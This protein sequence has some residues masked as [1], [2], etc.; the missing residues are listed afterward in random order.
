MAG[1]DVRILI[2]AVD[3]ASRVLDS[4]AG[5]SAMLGLGMERTGQSL[6]SVGRG[7]Q[8]VADPIKGAIQS[9]MSLE[10]V[11]ADVNKVLGAEEVA[12]AGV[13]KGLMEMSRRIPMTVQGLAAISAAGGSLGLPAKEVLGFTEVAAKMGIA[14]DM[15][16]DR[17]GV[18]IAKLRNV[19]SLD[20]KGGVKEV[21]ALGDT[22]NALENDMSLNAADAVEAMTRIGGTT[23][24]FGLSADQAAA[25]ASSIIALGNA[26]DVAATA[27]NSILPSLQTATGGTKAFKDGLLMT[28]ISAEQMSEMVKKDGMGAINS[29]LQSLQRLDPEGRALAIKKMF[30]AGA[31]ARALNTLANDAGQL[32][33]ALG[34]INDKTKKQGSMEREF[35][36]RSAT[37][38]NS[39]QL[40]QN[41]LAE[42]AITVGSVLLPA[43]ESVTRAIMPVVQGFASFAQTYPNV[44]KLAAAALIV[45]AG[46]GAIIVALG[47]VISFVGAAI[48]G[49]GTLA[50]A[51][52]AASGAIVAAT[53]WIA[54]VG[55]IGAIV[56]S[57]GTIITTALGGAAAAV[58]AL[59]LPFIAVA[60]LVAGAAFL[61]V[62]N[63]KPISAFFVGLFTNPIATLK[64]AAATIGALFSGLPGRVLPSL[65]GLASSAGATFQG[66]GQ[67]IA[68][69]FNW[70]GEQIAGFWRRIGTALT[71]VGAVIK[72][73]FEGWLTIALAPYRF[74]FG[75]L[76][77][78]FQQ[79]GQ[80]IAPS[81]SG[82]GGM[83]AGA[84][85]LVRSAVSGIVATFTA[86][87][88]GVRQ[89]IGGTAS[90]VSATFLG[91][92][93]VIRS[94]LDQTGAIFLRFVATIRGVLQTTQALVSGFVGGVMTTVGGIATRVSAVMNSIASAVVGF[95]AQIVGQ[96]QSVVTAFSTAQ[97]SGQSM[98]AAVGA[99]LGQVI[100]IIGSIIARVEQIPQAFASIGSQ[101]LASINA[102]A[103]QMFN[104]G[105]N[106]IGQLVGGI[107][108]KI[109][110]ATS[111]M[112]NA[113]GQMRAYLPFSPAKVGPLSDLDRVDFL[114]TIAQN[115][116]PVPLTSAIQAAMN[117]VQGA[118]GSEITMP[119]MAQALSA[120]APTGTMAGIA[121]EGSAGTPSGTTMPV[122]S[123]GGVLQV[124]ASITVTI[125]G[126]PTSP[127]VQESLRSQLEAH[128]STIIRIMENHQRNQ[129]RTSYS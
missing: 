105:A 58:G 1:T 51:W 28:G 92:T 61:I 101:I 35:A 14:F 106:M 114:G 94:G 59:G 126:D 52:A 48:A 2:T 39:I 127:Q 60:A 116:T 25:L 3:N 29:L 129:R 79:L 83:I 118:I 76:V 40:L 72:S 65:R 115:I 32:T 62:R 22:I 123:Q 78:L 82:L 18:A 120:I 34:I 24:T 57:V 73:L 19:F 41:N 67:G 55:G 97:A 107:Q 64:S 117:A 119:P 27:I 17:A 93:A 53:A 37:T 66:M 74:A 128:Q 98:G 46:I 63:W 85:A 121:A 50:G 33:K 23:R 125:N 104:A 90:Q 111:A 75:F 87:S 102:V 9:A 42:I 47:T 4:I 112:S 7:M 10:S 31:D 80:A 26:P 6:A 86:M 36:S 45:T 12:A 5:K 54:S 113:V 49:F 15:S 11:M 44:T 84:L 91:V 88:A 89:S 103:S 38:A 109:G 21:Q 77:G 8:S 71:P 124:D 69:A 99:A 122:S 96:V 30:G 108:S 68:S 95:I 100:N 70:V 13:G 81:L 43:L 56:A 20:T 16:A 110:E